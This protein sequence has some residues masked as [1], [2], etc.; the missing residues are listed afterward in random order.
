MSKYSRIKL[1]LT[2][3]SPKSVS[4]VFLFLHECL[5][6]DLSLDYFKNNIRKYS[7]NEQYFI[8]H[9]AKQFFSDSYDSYLNRWMREQEQ[10]IG[11]EETLMN[12]FQN[13]ANRA[14]NLLAFL[15]QK[16]NTTERVAKKIKKSGILITENNPPHPYRIPLYFKAKKRKVSSLDSLIM[17]INAFKNRVKEII[18]EIMDSDQ[19][20][21]FFYNSF[22]FQGNIKPIELLYI[23]MGSVAD[24]YSRFHQLYLF[25]KEQRGLQ[26]KIIKE[27]YDNLIKKHIENIEKSSEIRK[28]FKRT[29]DIPLLDSVTRFDFMKVMYNTFPQIRESTAEYLLKHPEYYRDSYLK[30]NSRNIK[31]A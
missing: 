8:M 15:K 31:S 27:Y 1:D 26:N 5:E 14:E 6:N 24:V 16:E 17:D 30:T 7:V 23:E 4:D 25:Y 22:A 21:A 3:L 10:E 11:R 12:R 28:P 18:T 13:I 29:P 20:E 19:F 9:Y 2:D